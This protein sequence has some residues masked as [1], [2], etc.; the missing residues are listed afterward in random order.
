MP[1]RISR[2][3]VAH[4]ARLARLTL[5]DDELD[6]Y[7]DQLADILGHAQDMASLDLTGVDLADLDGPVPVRIDSGVGDVDV[8]VPRSAD[9]EVTVS[10][11]LGEPD[12]FGES[13]DGG[14]SPGVGSA[15]WTGDDE[16]EFRITVES[17]IGDVE[18]SR[19]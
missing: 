1:E 10:S 6:R 18:V 17:G 4:V 11:G 5:T 12:V 19:G 9:V 2:D 13:S 15:S 8:L 3:D 7:T 14:F 16:A